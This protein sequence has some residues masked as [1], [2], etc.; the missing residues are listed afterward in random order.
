[1]YRIIEFNC[2]ISNQTII[3]SD[4]YVELADNEID[5]DK[6]VDDS[7]EVGPLLNFDPM[8]AINSTFN[9]SESQFSSIRIEPDEQN[10]TI[11]DLQCETVDSNLDMLMR[12]ATCTSSNDI[13]DDVSSSVNFATRTSSGLLMPPVTSNTLITIVPKI[14]PKLV[15]GTDEKSSTGKPRSIISIKRSRD[16]DTDDLACVKKQKVKLIVRFMIL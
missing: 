13:A 16:L 11:L 6:V 3:F 2:H 9:G 4:Y 12:R 10:M 5:G 7:M 8:D 14:E 1:M 15:D